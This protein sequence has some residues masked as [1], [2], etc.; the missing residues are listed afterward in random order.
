MFSLVI[1]EGCTSRMSG[2]WIHRYG[3][4]EKKNR[5]DCQEL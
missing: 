4:T 5:Q 2:I 1:P 3:Y